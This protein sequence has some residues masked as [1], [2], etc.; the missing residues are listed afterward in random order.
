MGVNILSLYQQG[1]CNNKVLLIVFNLNSFSV[2]LLATQ[3]VSMILLSPRSEDSWCVSSTESSARTIVLMY[4]QSLGLKCSHH[5][6]D[7]EFETP[8]RLNVF[9]IR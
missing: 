7:I 9:A 2:E 3:I 5:K 4:S 8:G 1:Y 6:G